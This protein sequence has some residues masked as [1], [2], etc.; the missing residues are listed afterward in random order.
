MSQVLSRPV[1]QRGIPATPFSTPDGVT[2]G[3]RLPR[4]KRETTGRTNAPFFD[5]GSGRGGNSRRLVFDPRH[6][7]GS[8]LK[9]PMVTGGLAL[10]ARPP[11]TIRV[12][13]RRRSRSTSTSARAR[14]DVI[15]L[16]AGIA[17][18]QVANRREPRTFSELPVQRTRR[19]PRQSQPH[20]RRG[21][22][23]A[24]ELRAGAQQCGAGAQQV[25]RR[26]ATV[27]RER[28]TVRRERA[29]VRHERATVR[30]RGG[31][32]RR[33]CGGVYHRRAA[34]KTLQ[35]WGLTPPPRP[36]HAT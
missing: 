14:S 33:G 16:L 17:A 20:A 23:G 18:N 21:E 8:R 15:G 34:W 27:R 25:R 13:I 12:A 1:T 29:T 30:R 9:S 22:N 2:Q 10:R 32:V 24:A 35:C 5:R 4:A 11:V 19:R 31:T 7:P 26:S 3:S 28:T 6:P 36:P